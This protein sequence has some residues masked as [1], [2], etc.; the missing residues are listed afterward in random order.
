[1]R[2]EVIA[3]A[4]IPTGLDLDRAAVR[5]ALSLRRRAH[6]AAAQQS[7]LKRKMQLWHQSVLE[8]GVSRLPWA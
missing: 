1:M 7:H 6:Q 3:S 5:R 8:K 2:L 4:A